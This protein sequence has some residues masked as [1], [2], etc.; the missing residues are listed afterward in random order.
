MTRG[1]RYSTEDR[2]LPD[3]DGA[4]V[5]IADYYHRTAQLRKMC[6]DI[7]DGKPFYAKAQALLKELEEER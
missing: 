5:H 4:W 2:M 6:Q 3:S 1:R 7:V